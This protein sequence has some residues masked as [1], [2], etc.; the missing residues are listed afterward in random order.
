MYYQ[1]QIIL[2]FFPLHKT[3]F[4]MLAVVLALNAQTNKPPKKQSPVYRNE[5]GH[6]VYTPATAF[7][8][9]RIA[10]IWPVNKPFPTWPFR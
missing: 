5:Q 4:L 9:F 7:L 3:I 8:I 6:L 2:S 1:T 10:A